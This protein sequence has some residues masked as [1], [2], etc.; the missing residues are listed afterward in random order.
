[1]RIF[2]GAIVALT[3]LNCTAVK[4]H[5][6]SSRDPS[7]SG[8]KVDA[9][10]Y[11]YDPSD[12]SCGGFPKLKVQ[13][14]SGTCLG[15]VLP[16]DQI[17]MGSGNKRVMRMPRTI[18]QVPGSDDFL[19]MDMG[20]WAPKIGK[21]WLMQIGAKNAV[22]LTVIKDKLT[23]PHA[24][25]YNKQDGFYYIGE[26]LKIS[27]FHY[28]DGK[29]T[30]E[31][32][33]IDALPDMKGHMHPLTQLVF[34]P[35]N[36]DMYINSGAPSD[37]CDVE[38]GG[39]NP[40]CSQAAGEPGMA[41]ILRIKGTLLEKLPKSGNSAKSQIAMTDIEHVAYGLRNSMAMA[42]HPAGQYLVQ[43]ENGRDFSEMEEPY[44]EMNTILIS[45]KENRAYHFGW[46]Y[47]YNFYATSPEWLFPQNANAHL[48]SKVEEQPFQCDVID[49]TGQQDNNLH[50]YKRPHS[51]IP[52]HAAPLHALYYEGEMFKDLLKNKLL[53]SWHGYRPTGQRF[54]SYSVSDTGRPLTVSKNLT[55]LTF[56]VNQA[57]G[58][59]Q[60][61]PMKP[62]GK[63]RDRHAPYT[64]VISGWGK[65]A[66]VR[67]RG[68]PTGFTVAND[69]SIFIVDDKNINIVRL[70]NT[71]S[72][73]HQDKCGG[74]APPPTEVSDPSIFMLAWRNYFLGTDSKAQTAVADYEAIKS[75]LLVEKHCLGCH[76]NFNSKDLQDGTDQFTFMDYI[77]KNEWVKPGNADA[78]HLYAAIKQNG[79]AMP[80]PPSDKSPLLGTKDGE[81][82][83]AKVES[84][85]KALPTDIESRT[86]MFII[87]KTLNIRAQPSKNATACGQYKPDDVVYFDPRPETFKSADGFNWVKTYI[88]PKSTR[89]YQNVCKWPIDG[90]FYIAYKP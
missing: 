6:A 53:M 76:D 85:I 35:K 33:V 26:D 12:T 43:G 44:E 3:L 86:K 88:P 30:D 50:R 10:G 75:G 45:E 73:N 51:L 81:A 2:I 41:Q 80:M 79:G 47:C 11:E 34:N 49:N 13:T 39:N 90:V 5:E 89:L 28:A 27:R 42:I 37:H 87:D 57:D 46:P 16:Q 58:C 25:E 84:W 61:M 68:A 22:T 29:I 55:S 83:I 40:L 59:A 19:V 8:K 65:I 66:K 4:K 62:R 21:I 23:L 7:A 48:K 69:G 82:T 38:A 78:S 74:N 52:P 18:V 64:E 17:P 36:N 20:G 71:G 32:V 70:A 63:Y 54:V 9:S 14:Q 31:Q 1:M 15:L 67:P 60:Q 77:V 56:G 72:A 24:L